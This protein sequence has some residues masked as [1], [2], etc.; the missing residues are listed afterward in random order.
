MKLTI[1]KSIARFAGAALFA[2][3]AVWTARADYYS[4]IQALGPAG[5]W[6]FTET[7]ASPPLNKITNAIS[8]TGDLGTGYLVKDTATPV[9]G[10][11]GLIGP[12][13]LFSNPGNVIAN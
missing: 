13:I 8:L 10:Q 2:A 6:R 11:P 4:T 5:Y 3:A 7:V 12:S 1:P 9:L